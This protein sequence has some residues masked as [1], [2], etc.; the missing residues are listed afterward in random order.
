MR[1]ERDPKIVEMKLEEVLA[2]PEVKPPREFRRRDCRITKLLLE[3][4]GFSPGCPGCNGMITGKRGHAHSKESRD[5]MELAME[6]DPEDQQRIRNRD[7]RAYENPI[8]VDTEEKQN[9]EKKNERD[10]SSGLARGPDGAERRPEEEPT[11]KTR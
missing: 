9:D 11:E 10:E 7:Q 8:V 5:R 2:P 3:R 6:A 4:Y 1:T